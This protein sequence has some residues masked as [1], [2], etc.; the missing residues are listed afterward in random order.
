VDIPQKSEQA[1]Q[2]LIGLNEIP[3]EE[4]QKVLQD[5][6]GPEVLAIFER[7]CQELFPEET[8]IQVLSTL[9][10]LMITGYLVAADQQNTVL[11]PKITLAE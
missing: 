1:I 10:H 11:G 5:R 3:L 2:L 7:Y 9:V 6:I 8:D 4:Y